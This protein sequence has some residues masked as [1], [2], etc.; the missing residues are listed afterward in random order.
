MHLDIFQMFYNY[1][2]KEIVMSDKYVNFDDNT[3]TLFAEKIV[4]Q[5]IDNIKE[6]LEILNLNHFLPIKYHKGIFNIEINFKSIK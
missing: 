2:S 1:S 4:D 5:N 3:Y 6:L